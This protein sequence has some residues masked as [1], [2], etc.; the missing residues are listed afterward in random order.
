MKKFFV[1]FTIFILL[2]FNNVFAEKINSYEDF[3]YKKIVYD[4]IKKGK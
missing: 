3:N 2:N 1:L 4:P